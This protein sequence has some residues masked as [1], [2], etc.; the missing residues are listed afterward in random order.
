MTTSNFEKFNLLLWKN[1]ILGLRHWV[2]TI[3]EVLIPVICCALLILIRALVT[4]DEYDDPTIFQ[5]L[6]LNSV[7]QVR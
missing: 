7:Q 2:Q 1:Y 6:D 5:E 3:F 4:P